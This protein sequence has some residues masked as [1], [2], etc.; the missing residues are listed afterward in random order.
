MGQR[1]TFNNR[2]EIRVIRLKSEMVAPNKASNCNSNS[3]S[4]WR[5]LS[6]LKV[7]KLHNNLLKFEARQPLQRTNLAKVHKVLIH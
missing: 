3:N 6:G 2:A 1:K 4:N 5:L 7:G